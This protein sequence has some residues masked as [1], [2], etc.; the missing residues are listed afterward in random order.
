M[1]ARALALMIIAVLIG[2]MA[3]AGTASDI[4]NCCFVDRQCS[5]DQDWINGWHAFQNN[6]CGAAGQ[7]RASASSQSAGG[8]PAQIDNCC[9]VDRQCHS[10]QDWINGW[11]AYQNN[12]CGAPAQ[13]QPASGAPAQVD[14]CCYVDRQCNTNQDWING[15]QAYQNN[16]CGA[17]TQTGAPSSYQPGSGVILRTATGVVVGYRNGRS[18]LPS[19]RPFPTIPLGQIYSTNNCCQQNWQCNSDQDWAAGYQARQN[20]QCALPGLISVV[21]DPVFVDLFERALDLLKNRLPQRYNYV[22]DGV[23]KVEQREGF[24]TGINPLSRRFFVRASRYRDRQDS[25]RV[26]EVATVLVHEA[27]HVHRFNAGYPAGGKCDREGNNREINIREEGACEE[28][29]LQ[30]LIELGVEPAWIEAQRN[31]VASIYAGEVDLYPC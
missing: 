14:N 22:L 29:E 5:S 16:Q 26:E 25:P 24:V 18:I 11:Q 21:G 31:F 19:T 23:D 2:A 30:V 8:A 6:Q 3:L 20:R 9:Y 12:L 1:T 17:P 13:S 27:C 10:D 28:M 15:W 4:D 7:S